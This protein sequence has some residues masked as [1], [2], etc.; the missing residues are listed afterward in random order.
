M[1]T[2][3]RALRGKKWIS[4]GMMVFSAV[5]FLGAQAKVEIKTIDGIPHVLNPAKPLKGTVQLEVERL[6]TIDPYAQADVGRRMV[7][8][9]RDEAGNVILY[10]PN[11]AE[12]HRFGPDG[13]YL[14]LLTRKGQGPGEF[15][16]MQGYW[17]LFHGPEIWIYGGQKV[18]HFDAT[19]KFLKDR[20]LKHGFDAG[21]EAGRFLSRDSEATDEKTQIWRLRLVEFDMAGAE[22][23]VDLLRAENIEMIRNPSVQGAFGDEWGTPRFFFAADSSLKRVYCGLNT[24]YQISVRDYAGRTLLVI[25]KPYDYVK[26]SRADVEK[27]MSWA[28]KNERSKWILSAYPDR[29]V[30]V[31]DVKPLPKGYLAVY[32]VAGVKK[33]EIDV[34][35]P[36]GRYLYA[37]IPPGDVKMDEAQFFNF[38]FGTVEQAEESPIYREYRVKNL[39]EVFAK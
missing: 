28:L 27:L 34:F 5:A 24:K 14:G 30:A 35:D 1:I 26:V 37:L 13:K 20:I 38:G 2:W 8:F 11:G 15:S 6:R 25:E 18:A 19:G 7:R 29:L 4:L 32:R 16:P 31:K 3:P 33:V 23:A 39:P 22:N 36:K 17:A 10:D 9:S 21:V 12:A